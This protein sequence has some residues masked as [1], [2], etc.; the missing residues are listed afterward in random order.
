[1]LAP[2]LF[3]VGFLFRFFQLLDWP[4]KKDDRIML[5]VSFA[6]A[7]A[8]IALVIL[9]N[10][11]DP[12]VWVWVPIL[13]SF[14]F[15]VFFQK[16][17]LQKV[18]EF[19]VGLFCLAT[20]MLLLFNI[21]ELSMQDVWMWVL[22]GLYAGYVAL[23]GYVLYTKT[24]ISRVLQKFLVVLHLGSMV[25]IGGWFF[26]V[27][28]SNYTVSPFMYVFFGYNNVLLLSYLLNLFMIIPND[29][30][31]LSVSKEQ[32]SLLQSKYVDETMKKYEIWS[33]GLLGVFCLVGYWIGLSLLFVLS[34]IL[35]AGTLTPLFGKLA[36]L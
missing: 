8:P 35:I 21:S 5:Y 16:Q 24:Q 6:I 25:L 27:A 36:K 1:M 9:F 11:Y 2:L 12:A 22:L 33:L 17:L 7:L 29:L 26:F 31:S 18:D 10:G 19:T 20:S 3:T 28:I 23:V 32:V 30:N 4:L 14:V 13:V 34:I 15:L